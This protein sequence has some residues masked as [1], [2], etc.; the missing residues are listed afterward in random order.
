M[1]L[2]IRASE[3]RREAGRLEELAR[4]ARDR[5]GDHYCRD[6]RAIEQQLIARAAEAE[7]RSRALE[8]AARE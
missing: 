1:N 7:E 3:C 4:A 5:G 8:K 6:L 2:R